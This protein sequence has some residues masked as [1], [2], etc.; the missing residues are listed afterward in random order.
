MNIEQKWNT[1]NNLIEK[2]ESTHPGVTSFI[3][4]YGQRILECPAGTDS[5]SLFSNPGGLVDMSLTV[6]SKM[7]LLNKSLD[8]GE[9]DSNILFVG[10]FHNVGAIGDEEK[11]YYIQQDSSWHLQKGIYYKYNEMIP[12]MP[13]SH[14]SLYLMQ[15]SGISMSYDEWV[16][17]AISG[18]LHREESKFYMG[19]E[20]RLS[21][22]LTQARQWVFNRAE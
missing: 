6:T 16:S 18:G 12:K 11:S 13:I 22:L 7:R 1:F 21:I 20:P 15:A 8:I 4:K 2:L 19:T 3:E 10:L 14:R 5:S 17:I 9:K